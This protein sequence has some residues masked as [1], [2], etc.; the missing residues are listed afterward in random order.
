MVVADSFQCL[1]NDRDIKLGG[2]TRV[3]PDQYRHFLPLYRQAL[4]PLGCKAGLTV[5]HH[6]E[7]VAL[8]FVTVGASK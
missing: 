5:K 2:E 8:Q 1:H 3:R 4:L 6:Y 7:P